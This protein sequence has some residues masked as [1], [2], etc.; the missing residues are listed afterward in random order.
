MMNT[1][2]LTTD[3]T[4][5]AV[6]DRYP[7][8]LPVFARHGIDLCCGGSKTLAFVAEAHGLELPALLAE[9]GQACGAVTIDG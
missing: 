3:L 7:A 2:A 4:V 5:A 6:A 9:L 8:T 1:S